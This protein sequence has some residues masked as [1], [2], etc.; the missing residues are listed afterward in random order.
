M[1]YVAM[2]TFNVMLRNVGNI[3]HI[4]NVVLWSCVTLKADININ[5]EEKNSI[6]KLGTPML[7]A[8]KRTTASTG[9]VF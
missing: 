2:V 9:Y 4:V 6:F 1:E 3:I 7:L 8:Y 5:Y